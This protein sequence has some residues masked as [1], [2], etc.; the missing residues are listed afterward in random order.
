VGS[1]WSM[2]HKCGPTLSRWVARLVLDL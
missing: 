2:P 1:G